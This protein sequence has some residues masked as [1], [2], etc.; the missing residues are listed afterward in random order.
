MGKGSSGRERDVAADDL[1]AFTKR[2]EGRHG[3]NGR[4]NTGKEA[5]SFLPRPTRMV[6][7]DAVYLNPGDGPRNGSL[8]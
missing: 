7:R 8:N 1:E 5:V 4:E 6:K 3:N 2:I